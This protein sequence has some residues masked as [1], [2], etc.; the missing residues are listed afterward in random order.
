MD[1]F[2][3]DREFGLQQRRQDPKS[4]QHAINQLLNFS[5]DSWPPRVCVPKTLS[6]FI[7]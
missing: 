1:A 6:G 2:R 4:D 3:Q 7:E 5:V